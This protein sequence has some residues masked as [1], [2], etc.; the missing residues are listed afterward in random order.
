MVYSKAIRF[1]AFQMIR[2]LLSRI[3]C[4][5]ILAGSVILMMGIA[6]LRSDQPALNFLAIGVLLFF[7]GLALWQKLR[8][9]QPRP[10]RFSLLRRRGR[11]D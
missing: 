1:S 7:P 9:R 11:R 4:L 6:A 3:G 5:M 8:H 10:D 2:Y